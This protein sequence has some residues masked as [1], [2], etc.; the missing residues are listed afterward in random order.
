[1][2]WRWLVLGILITVL[3]ACGK[4]WHVSENDLPRR[5]EILDLFEAYFRY[6]MRPAVQEGNWTMYLRLE[7]KNPPSDLLDRFDRHFHPVKKGSEY[8]RE[9][10]NGPTVLHFIRSYEW[11]SENFVKITGGSYW[12]GGIGPASGL[13]VAKPYL[14]ERKDGKWILKSVGVLK[15]GKWILNYEGVF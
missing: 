15:H 1:M 11:V 4:T 12:P 14:W 10:I 5:T 7:N 9:Y 6:L 2:K 3:A 13:D 8:V